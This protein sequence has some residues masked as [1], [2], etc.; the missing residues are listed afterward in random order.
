MP[1]VSNTRPGCLVVETCLEG[2]M[3]GVHLI[4]LE[5][6]EKEIGDSVRVMEQSLCSLRFVISVFYL[7]YLD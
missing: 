3:L 5:S 7:S 2:A 6:M 4:I 1:Q